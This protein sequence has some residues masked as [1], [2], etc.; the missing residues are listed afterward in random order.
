[1]KASLRS[2]ISRKP[3]SSVAKQA[4]TAMP[5]EAAVPVG[6]VLGLA[7][8]NKGATVATVECLPLPGRGKIIL[9]GN[10]IGSARDAA[11]LAVSLARARAKSLGL[12]PALFLH[13]DL[14]FHVMDP[15]PPKSGPSIGLPMFVALVSALTRKPVDPTFA[16]TGELSLTGKVYAVEGIE[17]KAKAAA[18]AGVTKL[19]APMENVTELATKSSTRSSSKKSADAPQMIGVK[20]VEAALKAA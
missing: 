1:M 7:L 9:T 13:T 12:D 4:K 6:V 18:K 3:A 10:L 16:F 19:F 11:H 15:L 8:T 14:H 20:V 5:A 2:G 17:A